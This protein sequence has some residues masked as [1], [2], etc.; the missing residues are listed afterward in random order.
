MLQFGQG[1]LHGD[2]QI[3]YYGWMIGTHHTPISKKI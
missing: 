2:L 3:L 1:L